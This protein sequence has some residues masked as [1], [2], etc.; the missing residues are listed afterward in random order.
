MLPYYTMLHPA[1]SPCPTVLALAA[2]ASG[3]TFS[4]VYLGGR[5]V[6][7]NRWMELGLSVSYAVSVLIALS[8]TAVGTILPT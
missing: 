3:I 4:C 2:H 8:D 5:Y 6:I 1:V 7:G